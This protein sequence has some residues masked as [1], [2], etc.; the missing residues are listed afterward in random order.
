MEE[1]PNVND[2]NFLFAGEQWTETI[3][4]KSFSPFYNDTSCYL[5]SQA[6]HF[7]L[8]LFNFIHFQF[9]NFSLFFYKLKW[10]YNCVDSSIKQQFFF[11]SFSFKITCDLLYSI[12]KRLSISFRSRISIGMWTVLDSFIQ[13]KNR[14]FRFLLPVL[15]WF[16]CIMLK[17]FIYF[18]HLFG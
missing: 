13:S 2:F 18:L 3:K 16:S 10:R 8:L 1:N 17:W 15:S 14:Y 6:S 12:V 7:F 11:I 9:S 5:L 4:K